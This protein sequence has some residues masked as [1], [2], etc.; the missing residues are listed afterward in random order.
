MQSRYIISLVANANNSMTL[1]LSFKVYA[2]LQ[3]LNVS[4][5]RMTLLRLLSS[6]GNKLMNLSLSGRNHF[7]PFSKHPWLEKILLFFVNNV[8]I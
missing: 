7:F 1:F 3:K 6:I 4:I 5:S 8:I 2:R